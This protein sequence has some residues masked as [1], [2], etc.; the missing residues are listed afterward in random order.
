MRRC[1]Y[2]SL[3]TS[4]FDRLRKSRGGWKRQERSKAECLVREPRR[5]DLNVKAPADQLRRCAGRHDRV[6][7]STPHHV[8]QLGACGFCPGTAPGEPVLSCVEKRSDGSYANHR[9]RGGIRDYLRGHARPR[10]DAE[11]AVQRRHEPQNAAITGS[12]Q[13]LWVIYGVSIGSR[14]IIMW[15]VIAV[16]TNYLTVGVYMYFRRQEARS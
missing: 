2:S 1:A 11:S 12:F 13:I 6:A 5:N 8:P 16:G 15:N 4:F 10:C 7:R 3:R 14:N 9:L